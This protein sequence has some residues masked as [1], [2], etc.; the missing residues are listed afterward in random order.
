MPGL[1]EQEW[2]RLRQR[3]R[4]ARVAR[5]LMGDQRQMTP[6]LVALAPASD[7]AETVAAEGTPASDQRR[8]V[9]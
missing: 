2:A 4:A 8:P 7:D 9:R 6:L 1:T 3:E 5:A